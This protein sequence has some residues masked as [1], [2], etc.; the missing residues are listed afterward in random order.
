MIVVIGGGPAGRI[1]AMH[2]AEEGAEVRLVEENKIGGQCL[3]DRCMTICALNDVARLLDHARALKEI[4]IVDTV[5]TVSYPAVKR[6]MHEIQGKIAAV[7]DRE[8]RRAGVEV[9]YGV[10]GRLEGDRVYID[11]EEIRADAV[12][13]AT[14]S[15]AALP[16]IPGIDTTGVYTY[17]TLHTMDDLPRRMVVVGGGVVAAEF[18]HIFQSFG[19]EVDIVSRSGLLPDLDLRLRSAVMRHD[20]A[21]AKIHEGSTVAS[22]EGGGR[23]RSVL[24]TDGG[25]IET[26]AVF[27]ATGLTPRSES[28]EGLRK[29]SDGAVIVD[30]H[31]RTNIEGVYA[32][33]D[34]IGSPYLTPAARREGMVAAEN[35]LGRP[36]VMDYAGI[37]QAMSLYYD[38]AIATTGAADDAGVSLSAPSPAGPGSFWDVAR[39]WS[40]A[41]Q[42]KIDPETGKLIEASAAIPGASTLLSYISYLMMQGITAGDFHDMVG[43]HPS[44]DGI[45]GL[46]R[47]AA[48]MLQEKDVVDR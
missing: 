14:G 18:A 1:G 21:G 43:V 17:K 9:I 44:T 48:S 10:R 45:Y 20:L 26:D 12:L 19:S 47:Y 33:G 27:V 37:P 28:L 36:A 22:I 8:T 15:R 39:G 46:A 23:V 35:I 16:D 32:A 42:I 11:D 6:E 40:G 29:R 4:G 3:H 25:E 38:Y 31:M 2:L 7:L 41:V 34:V 13:A 5:P 30:Q 24:L